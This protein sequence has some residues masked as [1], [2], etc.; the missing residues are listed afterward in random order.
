MKTIVV[1]GTGLYIKTLTDGLASPGGEDPALREH[2]NRIASEKGV[3]G[4]QEALLA[5]SP[6]LYHSLPDKKN[7]RRLIRAL[8]LAE[9]FKSGTLSVGGLFQFLAYDVVT[10]HMLGADREYFPYVAPQEAKAEAALE[11]QPT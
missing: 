6:D 8:E 3:A 7:A 9:A 5:K 11:T 10:R 1:G 4:L 2:W